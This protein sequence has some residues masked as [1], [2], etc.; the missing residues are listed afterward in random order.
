MKYFFAF[1]VSLNLFAFESKICEIS[2][3]EL[4]LQKNIQNKKELIINKFSSSPIIANE[5]DKMLS[6]LIKAKSPMI[7]NWVKKRQLNPENES[8]KI[9]YEWRKYFAMNFIVNRYPT[10]DEAK[11]EL[12]DKL[13]ED[14]ANSLLS[15]SFKNLLEKE[16]QSAQKESIEEINNLPLDKND[17]KVIVEKIKLIKIYWP[18]TL[19][20]SKYSKSPLEFFDWSLAYDPHFNEINIGLNSIF[21]NSLSLKAALIHEIAHSFDSCR[22]SID[23]TKTWPF[24]KIGNC[25]RRISKT[26]DDSQLDKLLQTKKMIREDYD[27]FKL[28][29]TCNNSAY[30]PIGI[31]ADQL[32]ESFADWFS[33]QVISKNN[34][35]LSL[36]KDLCEEKSLNPGSSYLSNHDRLYKIYL[37]NL[38]IQKKLKI[39]INEEF[40]HF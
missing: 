23:S 39:E 16:F 22:W 11:D 15:D 32:P 4:N 8:S 12:I 20:N 27:Y 9:A 3:S 34:L 10:K 37:S 14:I 13:F 31:Q 17:Q 28:H 5:A 26:R 30:P 2:N 35:D 6:M 18:K 24:E 40:C 21:Y 1:F 38:V 25:L 33:S 19:K 36:R 29:P 7:F